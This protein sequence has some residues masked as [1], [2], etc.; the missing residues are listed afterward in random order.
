MKNKSNYTEIE[1]KALWYLQRYA[2]SSE[3]LRNYLRRKVK[4]SH[5]SI[6]S[7]EIINEIIFSL[8]RQK[9]LN[10][11]LFSESK[12]RNYLNKGWSLKKIEFKLKELYVKDNIIIDAIQNIRNSLKNVDLIAACRLA[13]KKSIG[14]YRKNELTEKIKMRELGVLSRA[15]FSYNIVKKILFE[16]SKEELEDIYDQR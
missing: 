3:N 5:L 12:I 6:N 11:Q 14:P 16:M 8:E 7:E 9:I 4:D 15:G 1:S 2:S 13:K 10:D